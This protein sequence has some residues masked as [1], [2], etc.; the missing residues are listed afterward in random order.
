MKTKKL[1]AVIATVLVGALTTTTALADP[2]AS[3][4]SVVSLE[5]FQISWTGGPQVDRATDIANLSVSSSQLTAANMTGQPGVTDNPSTS[6]GAPLYSQSVIGPV[7]VATGIPG[8]S[9]TAFSV[10]PLPSIGNYSASA[11][12]DVGAPIQNFPNSTSPVQANS[13]LHNGSYASLDTLAGSAGT[14]TSSQLTS[15]VAFTALRS[16]SLTFNFDTGAYIA[17]FLSTNAG[18]SASASWSVTFTMVDQTNQTSV[19]SFSLGDAISNNEPG[20]GATNFGA[21]NAAA[22]GGVVALTAQS[23]TTSPL[24]AGRN[25]LITG[26]ISTRTQVERAVPAPEPDTLA[27]L[28]I[29]LLGMVL[30]SRKF[31]NSSSVTYA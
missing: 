6:T 13:D 26:N 27:L 14:S 7:P 30:A 10:I 18:V 16:G 4:E 20:S 9:L 5:N 31:K 25:Y 3:A 21:F 22:P 28:G 23:F 15:T 11:S 8:N 17:A 1:A 12:N 29:G 2:V 19:G 24:V